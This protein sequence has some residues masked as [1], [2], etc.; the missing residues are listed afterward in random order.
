[1]W[2]TFVSGISVSNNVATFNG[3]IEKG[4][5]LVGKIK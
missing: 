4:D 1:M 3:N 5:K 2:L